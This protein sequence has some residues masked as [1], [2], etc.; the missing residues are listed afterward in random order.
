MSNVA[1][2]LDLLENQLPKIDNEFERINSGGCG[3]M[4]KLIAEQLDLLAIN[5]DIVC[6]AGWGCSYSK[7]TNQ[8]VNDMLDIDSEDN[9]PN[10]H[11]LIQVDGR[12]FDSEGEQFMDKESI[13]AFV[14]HATVLRMV[15][16]DIWN[17]T[18]DRDQEEG[19]RGYTK[20][21]FNEVF[22]DIV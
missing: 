17:C 3:I 12:I 7:M 13:C 10:S 5:Y 18:F 22:G 4:A 1:K 19:M 15:D 16:A 2:V 20:T 21:L 9:I 6:K 11:V 8:Q 14:D